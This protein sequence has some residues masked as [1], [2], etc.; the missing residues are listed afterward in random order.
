LVYV[1]LDKPTAWS[2][3]RLTNIIYFTVSLL[4]GLITSIF[5]RYS[6]ISLQHDAYA[7]TAAALPEI[8]AGAKAMG[9]RFVDMD[10]CLGYPFGPPDVDEEEEEEEEEEDGEFKPGCV[11]FVLSL[12]A[13]LSNCHF[14]QQAQTKALCSSPDDMCVDICTKKHGG[15]REKFGARSH[16]SSAP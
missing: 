12:C 2:I 3:D 10:E 15:D 11:E 8:V 4:L 7:R 16:V 5:V 1:S 13:M 6:W 9:Y 14:Q